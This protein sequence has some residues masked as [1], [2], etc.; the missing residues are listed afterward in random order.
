[1]KSKQRLKN[2]RFLSALI[3]LLGVL[4]G[5]DAVF[6]EASGTYLSD[7]DTFFLQK[8][9]GDVTE[10]EV[11]NSVHH[12]V[13]PVSTVGGFIESPLNGQHVY[14]VPRYTQSNDGATYFDLE[15]AV[16]RPT[17]VPAAASVNQLYI[18]PMEPNQVLVSI[19]VLDHN[20]KNV[21]GYTHVFVSESQPK[22]NI[23]FYDFDYGFGHDFGLPV[24]LSAESED[25][26]PI[27]EGWR[28]G[29]ATSTIFGQY[30]VDS[31]FFD[32]FSNVYNDSFY[33]HTP[34]LNPLL[35]SLGTTSTPKD[36]VTA[37]LANINSD[38]WSQGSFSLDLQSGT[39]PF[40][41][42][43]VSLPKLTAAVK[44]NGTVQLSWPAVFGNVQ[45]Y[46][47]FQDGNQIASVPGDATTFDV[48]G[49][50]VGQ[51]YNF[52]VKGVAQ[53]D[54]APVDTLL[55]LSASQLVT[56]VTAPAITLKGDNPLTVEL[57]TAFA[58]L[59]VLAADD[60]DGDLTNR[61]TVT[62][63]VDGNTPG[64]Y[65]LV[66]S[67]T[68]NAGNKAEAVRTVK[69]VDKKAPVLTL[70]G[71]NPLTLN[72]GSTFT[73]PGFTASDNFD[74]D[75]NSKV[76]VTGQVD[77]N[78]PGEY[79]LVYSVTDNAGNKAEVV[80]MVKV[81]DK[82]AP[83][84]TLKGDNPLTLNQGSTFNDP[85]FTASDNFD[86]DL[87]S[88]VT[89]TGKVDVNTPGEYALVYRVTDTAG[90]KAEVTRT[91]KVKAIGAAKDT[92]SPLPLTATNQYNWLLAGGA[93]LLAG[94]LLK[95]RQLKRR[96]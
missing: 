49:L 36:G 25:T 6:R 60:V 10:T 55:A 27:E 5:C 86:G 38:V 61:V 29:D 20:K 8:E 80:R 24:L 78:T 95:I 89:V 90:N 81:V 1:M 4:S 28:T 23:A 31:S 69:V 88:K 87:T 15:T 83:V 82:K 19:N 76:T 3:V 56:D 62:G 17:K 58:D 11:N 48:T 51:T 53:V 37:V 52:T 73:D 26:T 75:L 45:G 96:V 57:D 39:N 35:D 66:Y 33:N 40:A 2:V 50:T 72:Q 59:G 22:N 44:G 68:D 43:A 84:L 92:E 85:G 9:T 64:E 32:K 41:T 54:G 13:D 18:N 94:A 74:G 42:L 67:V 93:L 70:K 30:Q 16:G 91:V 34:V 63:Q 71:D 79:Q 47:I 65:Q 77:G 46:H 12:N 7:E 21:D 14:W